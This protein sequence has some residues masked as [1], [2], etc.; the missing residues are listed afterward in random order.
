[1]STQDMAFEDAHHDLEKVRGAIRRYHLALDRR[2][3]GDVAAHTALGEIMAALDMPW[4]SGA[5]ARRVD[6]QSPQDVA[7]AKD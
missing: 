7:A 4:V 2:Q 6:G 1:M 5:E 3:H